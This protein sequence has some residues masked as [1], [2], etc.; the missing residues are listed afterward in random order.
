MFS[1]EAAG[2]VS[3][4][5]GGAGRGG[6]GGGAAAP[7]PPAARG[8]VRGPGGGRPAGG[9]PGGKGGMGRRRLP[10]GRAGA[11][12]GWGGVGRGV[13]PVR[14]RRR[15]N[16]GR[17]GGVVGAGAALYQGGKGLRL[18]LLQIFVSGHGQ[19]GGQGDAAAP[20]PE[21]GPALLF[22]FLP[23]G[24]QRGAV[25]R[26]EEVVSRRGRRG[27]GR[28]FL[29]L[30]DRLHLVLDVVQGGAG[31]RGG[32]QEAV[33]PGLLRGEGFDGVGRQEGVVRRFHRA[34]AAGSGWGL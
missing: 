23:H 28:G 17:G 3:L 26:G 16:R 24:G 25:L 33:D 31:F 14:Q 29:R 5:K 18:F 11:V 20:P 10:D 27:L 2:V 4:G 1:S 8:E 22:L 21:G 9:G 32:G 7:G 19:Q 6:A 12:F 15:G 13:G 34:A 30:A